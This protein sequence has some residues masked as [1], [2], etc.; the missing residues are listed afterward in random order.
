VIT[1]AAGTG[2]AG[3]A[4]DGGPAAAAALTYPFGIAFDSAGNLFACD[5]SRVRRI[6]ATTGIITTV[7]GSGG[8]EFSGDGQAALLAGMDPRRVVVDAAGSLL[9]ADHLGSRIRRVDP[10]SGIVTTV[11]GIGNDR[12]GDNG[13]AALAQLSNPNGI[14]LDGQGGLLVA[15]T[16][17]FRVRRIDLATGVIATVAGNGKLETSGDGGAAL[18]AGLENPSDVAV[19]GAG[20]VYITGFGNYRVR[21]VSRATGNIATVAGTG[22]PGF[23]GDGGPATLARLADALALTV[24]RGGDIFVSDTYNL[25]VRKVTAA[26]GS[27]TTVAGN[28]SPFRRGDGGPATAAGLGYPLGL[29]LDRAG[30]L[31]I[32]DTL[33]GA[34]RRVDAA[35][36]VITTVAGSGVLGYSGDGGRATAAQLNFPVGIALDAAGNVFVADSYNNRIRRIDAATGLISTVAGTGDFNSSGDGGPATAATLNTPTG[37]AVDAEGNLFIADEANGRIRAVRGPIPP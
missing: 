21:K 9:I 7:A 14:A 37:I 32:A 2:A 29:A 36:G 33:N 4:G 22:K 28:G 27:I 26:T 34:V 30:N 3:F 17:N 13:P 16:N 35:S 23:S 1:T 25:R 20:N 31:L 5:S 18:A 6:A 8:F 19:D 24:T 15:D 10:V 12:I 11:A